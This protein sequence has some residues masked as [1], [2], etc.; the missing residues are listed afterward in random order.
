MKSHEFITE[1]VKISQKE[2]PGGATDIA[3]AAKTDAEN[4]I[5]KSTPLPGGK[6]NYFFKKYPD[7]YTRIFIVDP[8]A[9]LLVGKLSINSPQGF[10]EQVY[11][12]GSITVRE[13][14]QGQGIAKALYGIVLAVMKA[15]LVAGEA[16]T[17][18]GRRNWLSLAGIPGVEVSGY[19]KI[20]DA[21]FNQAANFS[22]GFRDKF[23]EL[24][25]ASGAEYWGKG[26]FNGSIRHYFLFPVERGDGA[27]RGAIEKSF[28]LYPN[29]SPDI[30]NT[31]LVAKWRGK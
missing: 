26:K 22:L 7:G 8:V 24:A 1:I 13:D 19:A 21:A 14:Y 2:Y 25:M 9:K 3:K 17:P 20:P 31:G 4:I 29:W 6:F 18:A 30:I 16:Q 11:Q 10:P 28:K 23:I 27:L 12:V 15:T 5:S